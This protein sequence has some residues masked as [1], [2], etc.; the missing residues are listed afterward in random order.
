MVGDPQLMLDDPHFT[1]QSELL[2]IE[3]FAYTHVVDLTGL[4]EFAGWIRTSSDSRRGFELGKP[5][6]RS[7]K[8]PLRVMYD[9]TTGETV[10]ALYASDFKCLGYAHETFDDEAQAFE[11]NS[12]ELVMAE[13]IVELYAENWERDPTIW[14]SLANKRIG[15]RYG[16]GEVRKALV[17]RLRRVA[18]LGSSRSAPS[19]PVA[20]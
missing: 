3:N 5:M 16:A 2:D 12:N 11:L 19:E 1:P 9:R 14:A 17:T 20:L 10:D 4:E 6:N 13:L 8:V 15:G 18:N 7:M